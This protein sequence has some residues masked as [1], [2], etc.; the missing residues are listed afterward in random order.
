M[1]GAD[2]DEKTVRFA[3][4]IIPQDQVLTILR[5]GLHGDERH[6]SAWATQFSMLDFGL[7]IE[8][9]D[10]LWLMPFLRLSNCVRR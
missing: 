3:F 4:K 6:P 2:L 7:R 9:R 10:G 5:V 8:V 1:I